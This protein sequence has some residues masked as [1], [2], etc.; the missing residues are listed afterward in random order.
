MV[1]AY[2]RSNHPELV[3]E[4]ERECHGVP[5]YTW[6]SLHTVVEIGHYRAGLQAL[7]ASLKY[8][9]SPSEIP[10][11]AAQIKHG[12]MAFVDLQRRYYQSVLLHLD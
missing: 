4:L 6:L 2:L 7:Q 1:D 8:C 12:F 10:A 11:R 9:Q 5:N 3:D